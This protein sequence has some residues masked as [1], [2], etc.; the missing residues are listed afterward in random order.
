MTLSNISES[1]VSM[2]ILNEFNSFEQ[3]NSSLSVMPDYHDV[4]LFE[5][6]DLVEHI[7]FDE[8][9]N[10]TDYNW[11]S[12]VVRYFI[13]V[14]GYDSRAFQIE[15]SKLEALGFTISEFSSR[16]PKW[17]QSITGKE[18]ANLQKELRFVKKHK[19]IE[20]IDYYVKHQNSEDACYITRPALYRLISNK[21]GVKFIESIISRMGQI[22]FFFNDFK[23]KTRS[24]QIKSLKA[25]I[26]ELQSEIDVLKSHTISESSLELRTSH[27]SY[28]SS[29]SFITSDAIMDTKE[30]TDEL[31]TIHKII[32]EFINRVDGR[33]ANVDDKLTS[34]TL[35]MDDLVGSIALSKDDQTASVCFEEH[36]LMDHI[37]DIFREYEQIGTQCTP[38]FDYTTIIS[39]MRTKRSDPECYTT[40]GREEQ[41]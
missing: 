6:V 8:G 37:H 22:I 38:E 7:P 9:F 29:N 39:Q 21:Y 26:D 4:D 18:D 20:N 34:I 24:I 13:S 28:A 23:S 17:I 35:R 1:R 30:Y 41:L 32:E 11:V 16:A 40:L 5:Y 14:S 2:N 25:V 33:I 36:P 3:C 12:N 27:E 15:V 19:L 31:S 10:H